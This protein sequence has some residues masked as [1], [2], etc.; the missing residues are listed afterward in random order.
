MIRLAFL[1][2]LR[3]DSGGIYQYSE[4]VR[5]ALEGIASHTSMQLLALV[6]SADRSLWAQV[7][8]T[9][10]VLLPLGRNES[11]SQ[12]RGALSTALDRLRDIAIVQRGR[13]LFPLGRWQRRNLNSE[14][15][16]PI[17]LVLCPA[18]DPF[19]FELELPSLMAIHDLQHR[20]Q[21]Q[22][23]EVSKGGQL[24][25]RE[26]VY[27]NA[28]RHCLMLLVDSEIGKEDVLNLYGEQGAD[29][30]RIRVLPF[31]PAPYLRNDLDSESVAEVRRR[32]GIP[33]TFLFYPA[34]FWPHKNHRRVVE[35]V[36]ELAHRGLEVPI[37]FTGDNRGRFV[38]ETFREVMTLANATGI[39]R[40]VH[41]LGYV[42]EGDMSALYSA[43]SALVMPTFFGPTNI[44]VVEA[45][46]FDLP[47]VTSDIRGIREQTGDAA[48]LVDPGDHLSIAAGI[49]KV[50][51][52]DS[53]RERLVQAGRKRL[54][55]YSAEDFRERLGSILDEAFDLINT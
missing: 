26:Y 35:A 3:S 4:S 42:S 22:F 15:K 52:D 47:V 12:S 27:R 20:L 48:V 21:P 8:E 10:W 41:H 45:W 43:A 23:P 19:A 51:T 46:N 29:P 14:V 18:P 49:E 9:G 25:V 11:A 28:V 17:D 31:V 34:R 38:K 13:S 7:G 39:D 32:H 24:E 16:A 6:R 30:D 33:E 55:S 2:S 50:L 54:E 5:A 40:L 37:V 36:V 44:P 1:P 53:E